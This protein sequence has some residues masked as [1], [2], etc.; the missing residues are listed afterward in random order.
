MTDFDAMMTDEMMEYMEAIAAGE[1]IGV[2]RRL[3]LVTVARDADTLK[4]AFD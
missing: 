2:Q 3:S 4:R 1:E